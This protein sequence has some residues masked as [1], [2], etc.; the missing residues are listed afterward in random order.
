MATVTDMISG[1]ED[2]LH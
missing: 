1:T 2:H